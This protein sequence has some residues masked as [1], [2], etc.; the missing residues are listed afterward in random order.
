MAAEEDVGAED[1]ARLPAEL[2]E[3]LVGTPVEVEGGGEVGAKVLAEEA[4]AAEEGGP[5]SMLVCLLSGKKI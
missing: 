3:Q 2:G 1:E 5:I 4:A